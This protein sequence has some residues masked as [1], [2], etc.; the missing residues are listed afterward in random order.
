LKQLWLITIAFRKF[1]IVGSKPAIG[2]RVFGKDLQ[3]D[4]LL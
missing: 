3:A 1:L 4:I 2:L